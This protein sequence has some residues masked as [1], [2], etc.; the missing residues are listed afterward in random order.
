VKSF[1]IKKLFNRF[2]SAAIAIVL[3]VLFIFFMVHL[4]P[5]DP[6]LIAAG[7][8]AA[9]ETIEAIRREMNLDKPLHI[10]FFIYISGL[11]RGDLGNSIISH[12][13]LSL[14]IF[15]RFVNTL[16]LSLCAIVVAIILGVCI[17]VIAGIKNGSIYDTLSTALATLGVCV[18]TFVLGYILMFIFSIKL[19]WFPS[20]EKSGLS[21]FVLP[22][23]T[24][25]AYSL[26]NIA[27]ITRASMIESL[28]QD[29]IRTA[30]A[31]GLRERKVIWKYA[32][33]NAMVPVVTI[34]GLHFG[35]TIAGAILTESVFNWPGVGTYLVSSIFRRD[36]PAVRAT[37]LMISL[38]IIFVNFVTDL[39]CF[40]IDPR[41][42]EV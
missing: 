23:I 42:K 18:P 5:G 13:P 27:R 14:E 39:I 12:L 36:F 3:V 19:N 26:A 10:Q 32:L 21:S 20:I 34:S 35:G 24:L 25:S 8:E 22:T 2:L 9:P 7:G 6:A 33:K 4:M 16:Q 40:F 29:Y 11:L 1:F 17:G 37:L 15:P 28:S 31:M 30:R 41:R 38:L